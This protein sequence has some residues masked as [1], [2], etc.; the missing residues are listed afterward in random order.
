L[1]VCGLEAQF[2]SFAAALAHLFESSQIREQT[3]KL[4]LERLGLYSGQI[5][6]A[7]ISHRQ[8]SS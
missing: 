5:S 1:T 3:I 6:V 4:V 2:A 7:L 8:Q